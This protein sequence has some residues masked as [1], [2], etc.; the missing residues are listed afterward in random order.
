MVVY[1]DAVFALNALLDYLL[2]LGCARLSGSQIRRARLALAAAVGGL[3]AVCCALPRLALL[4]TLPAQAAAL[5]LM[6]LIAYGF[7]R[8]TAWQCVL[9]LGLSFALC[10]VLTALAL[11]LDVRLTVLGWVV[12]YALDFPALVLTAGAAYALTALCFAGLG[13]HSGGD[14]VPVTAALGQK[15]VR[16]TA[17][18]DTGNTLRDPISG[19]PVMVA[20][21]TAVGMLLPEAARPLFTEQSLRQPTEL[22][23]RCAQ[24]CPQLRLRLIPYRA[25]GVRSAMLLAF[26]CDVLTMGKTTRKGGLIAISPTS[27]SD[28][29]AY[30]A[31]M[32]GT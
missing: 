16:F 20:E 18:R 8:R 23:R 2:L 26:R 11:L 7:K 3:Y 24:A 22:M 29:G 21:L 15:S 5:V 4:R 25:V 27:V 12:C 17:L 32:G 30:Q 31:L 6:V 14:L 13:G 9:V 19:Q 10:G 1:A 28:G